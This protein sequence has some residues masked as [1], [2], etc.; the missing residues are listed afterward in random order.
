MAITKS[1]GYKNPV[2][3]YKKDIPVLDNADFAVTETA[4]MSTS[5]TNITSPIDQAETVK[6]STKKVNNVYSGSGVMPSYMAVTK[7]GVQSL[8][9]VRDIYS[10]QSDGTTSSTGESC[11][12]PWRIDLPSKVNIT[13]QVPKSQYFGAAEAMA[14]INRAIGVLQHAA[15]DV[16]ILNEILR[17]STNVLS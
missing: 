9:Q 10:I 12:S 1:W 14:V 3:T 13:I 16:T 15:D 8:I 5:Y 11:C 2:S 17:G 7:E 4:T 6:V